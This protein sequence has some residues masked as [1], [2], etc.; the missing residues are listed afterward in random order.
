[1]WKVWPWPIDKVSPF[2]IVAIFFKTGEIRI[3]VL[4]RGGVIVVRLLN[5][6]CLLF[7]K[8]L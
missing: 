5:E 2:L 4:H 8:M 7:R 6:D 3:A 1:M